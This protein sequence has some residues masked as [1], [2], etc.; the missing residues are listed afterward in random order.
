MRLCIFLIAFN[1]CNN[2]KK[3]FFFESSIRPLN[4]CCKELNFSRNFYDKH[5]KFWVQWQFSLDICLRTIVAPWNSPQ[6]NSP[7]TFTPRTIAPEQSPLDNYLPDN[8]PPKIPPGQFLPQIFTPRQLP[9]NNSPLDNCPRAITPYDNYPLPPRTF[10]LQATNVKCFQLSHFEFELHLSEE[11][12]AT[13]D[14]RKGSIVNPLSASW[15]FCIFFST[16][17]RTHF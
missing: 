14:L 10:A 12:I 1:F 2:L 17:F 5:Y 13:I 15:L 3:Y 11:S 7:R 4:R 16:L 9:L 8:C 6:D